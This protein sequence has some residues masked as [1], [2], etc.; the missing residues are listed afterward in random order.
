METK[1]TKL[2]PTDIF[3]YNR[4]KFFTDKKDGFCYESNNSLSKIIG[5]TPQRISASISKL[6]KLQYIKND[7]TIQ[8]R[9]L[10]TTQKKLQ[11]NFSRI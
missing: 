6:I 7:G 9:Q 5:R 3:I 11:Y 10:K 8:Q 1:P 4:I 2:Y